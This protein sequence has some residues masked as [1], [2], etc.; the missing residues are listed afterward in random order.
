MIDAWLGLVQLAAKRDTA[1]AREVCELAGLVKGYGSTHRRGLGTYQRIVGAL[2]MPALA[3]DVVPPK[4][5]ERIARAREAGLKDPDGK[6]LR[7]ALGDFGPGL[8][9]AAE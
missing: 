5:A 8:V 9:R 6:A 3:R 1:L 7:E 2:V 4:A